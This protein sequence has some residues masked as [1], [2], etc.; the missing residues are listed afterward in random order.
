MTH[1]DGPFTFHSI[2][3]SVLATQLYIVVAVA[4]GSLPR[5]RRRRAGAA[6]RPARR[7]ADRGA[8]AAETE[9]HRVERDLHDGAQQRLLALRVHLRLAGGRQPGSPGACSTYADEEIAGRGR[10]AARSRARDPPGRASGAE[11]RQRAAQPRRRARPSPSRS[12]APAGAA[13]RAGRRRP[14]YYIVAE[15]LANAQKHS[16][17]VVDSRRR[18]HRGRPCAGSRR[19][20]TAS[21]AQRDGRLRAP[22]AARPR[23]RPRRH[24][25]G[26]QPRRPRNDANRRP[27]SAS[28][29]RTRR[30][31]S[32]TERTASSSGKASA[33]ILADRS[34]TSSSSAQRRTSTALRT[35]VEETPPDV[36]VT[37]IRMPPTQTDEGIRIAVELNE[38]R[39]EIGVVVLS[40]HLSK[41]H[42]SLVFSE[43]PGDG[44]TSSRTGSPTRT[45]S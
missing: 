10:G 9:R 42:A 11:P 21:A 2:S 17:R 5:G 37:D 35:L 24:V 8:R 44:P 41:A 30:S 33:R 15:A 45:S 14:C 20:T 29:W 4:I 38:T 28:P 43:A 1:Y 13:A 36:V 7:V 26:R 16:A 22:R 34:R 3:Q 23:G 25:H 31:G 32:S 19:A 6:R 40:Q 27:P 18:R 39:P 12:R